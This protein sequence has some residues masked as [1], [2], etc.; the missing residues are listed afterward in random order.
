M[1]LPQPNSE[2]KHLVGQYG[3]RLR[4]SG[5]QDTHFPIG[6]GAPS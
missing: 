1:H 6:R 4:P 2:L 3:R 5:Y